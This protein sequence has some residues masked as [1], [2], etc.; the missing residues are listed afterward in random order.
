[1]LN[2]NFIGGVSHSNKAVDDLKH[3]M[4]GLNAAFGFS[5]P[6]TASKDPKLSASSASKTTNKH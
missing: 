6:T 2:I 4:G 5:K 3:A 1:M